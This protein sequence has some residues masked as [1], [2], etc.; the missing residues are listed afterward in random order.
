MLYS[1]VPDR[2]CQCR[3]HAVLYYR[4]VNCTTRVGVVPHVERQQLLLQ[5]SRAHHALQ[6]RKGNGKGRVAESIVF[7]MFEEHPKEQ[8]YKAHIPTAFPK[9]QARVGVWSESNPDR[10]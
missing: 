2:S 7:G 3:L 6:R 9:G 8:P 4:A 10:Q 5:Q 1:I